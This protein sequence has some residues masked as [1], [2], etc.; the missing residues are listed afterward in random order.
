MITETSLKLLIL[1]KMKT[2][3]KITKSDHHKINKLMHKKNTAKTGK[4]YAILNENYDFKH[5]FQ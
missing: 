2:V 4:I 3:I 1:R 5:L